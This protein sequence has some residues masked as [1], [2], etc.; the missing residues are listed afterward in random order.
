[1]STRTESEIT[2]AALAREL[3]E[4]ELA[5][6]NTIRTAAHPDALRKMAEAGQMRAHAEQLVADL[7]TAIA[8]VDAVAAVAA[9]AGRG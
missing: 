6:A 2:A 5:I 8:E 1:M 4:A 7:T 9:K 3:R